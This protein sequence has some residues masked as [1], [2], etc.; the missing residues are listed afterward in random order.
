MGNIRGVI[1]SWISWLV[2]N[3]KFFSHKLLHY[4]NLKPQRLTN[5]TFSPTNMK[6]HENIT[7]RKFPAIRYRMHRMSCDRKYTLAGSLQPTDAWY[8]MHRMSCDRKYT[9]AGSLQPTDAWYRMH[10]MSCDRK[11]TLAG[12]LQPTVPY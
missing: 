9:L 12:S 8:R 4:C 1:F 5:H 11:Y 6:I 10:R 7:P 3:H 2:Q